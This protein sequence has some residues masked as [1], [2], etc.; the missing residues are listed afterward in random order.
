MGKQLR[1][2]MFSPHTELSAWGGSSPGLVPA[3][4]KS[5]I[6]LH[7]ARPEESDR[8]HWVKGGSAQEPPQSMCQQA[9]S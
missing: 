8:A 5:A 9:C 1:R 3:P 6:G 2:Q 7:P 4:G